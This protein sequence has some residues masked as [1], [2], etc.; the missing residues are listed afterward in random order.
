M[1]PRFTTGLLTCLLLAVGT[2]PAAAAA[3][4]KMDGARLY[5]E[6]TCI[7]CH[8]AEG[9][10]PVLPVYPKLAGQNPEYL[11]QQLMDIKKGVRKNAMTL[12]MAGIM[13]NV[14]EQEMRAIAD[15]LGGLNP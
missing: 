13:T 2:A 3:A 10:D 12:A 4:A 5:K 6:K 14:N 11:F 1:R 8:G 9:R 15:W 7:S